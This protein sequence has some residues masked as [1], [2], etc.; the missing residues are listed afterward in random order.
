MFARRQL[1]FEMAIPIGRGAQLETLD[2]KRHA[3]KGFARLGILHRTDNPTRLLCKT[4]DGKYDE[5][6]QKE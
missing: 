2:I 4:T 5:K 3:H 1:Q 6:K